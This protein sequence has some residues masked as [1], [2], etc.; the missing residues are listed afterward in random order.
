MEKQPPTDRWDAASEVSN[1]EDS[2]SNKENVE[3]DEVICPEQPD[4][5]LEMPIKIFNTQMTLELPRQRSNTLTACQD[6]IADQI[7]NTKN[8][9][10][11]KRLG[12][13]VAWDTARLG[14][15]HDW[16]HKTLFEADAHKY[17]QNPELRAKFFGTSPSL[18]VEANAYNKYWG[19]GLAPE[20][21]DINHPD[22]YPDKNLVLWDKPLETAK[23]IEAKTNYM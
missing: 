23:R 5:A 9:A 18:L 10:I 16:A 6:E 13:K 22:A 15:W 11:A 1:E 21:L 2:E 12:D 14:L 8:A 7:L 19:C 3:D 4:K 17:E 20:D